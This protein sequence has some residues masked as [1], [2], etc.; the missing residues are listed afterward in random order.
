MKRRSQYI[1]LKQIE[2]NKYYYELLENN[3]KADK[4]VKLAIVFAGKEPYIRRIG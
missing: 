1:L 2:L 4:I 3:I